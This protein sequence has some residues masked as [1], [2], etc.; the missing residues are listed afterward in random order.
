MSV[1][2]AFPSG[3][4]DKWVSACSYVEG[5]S[6]NVFTLHQKLGMA[7]KS[8]EANQRCADKAT[9]HRIRGTDEAHSSCVTL[10]LLKSLVLNFYQE[11]INAPRLEYLMAEDVLYGR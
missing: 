10:L 7:A 6:M 9:A 3:E 11:K 5:K 4:V 1:I 8:L 2:V